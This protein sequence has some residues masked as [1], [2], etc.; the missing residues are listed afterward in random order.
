M[1]TLVLLALL[2][3][4]LATA[5]LPLRAQEG[6]PITLPPVRIGDQFPFTFE[7]PLPPGATV[8]VDTVARSWGAVSVVD[9]ES[10][11]YRED[12]GGRAATIQLLLAAFAPGEVEFAPAV[13]VVTGTDAAPLTLGA[14]QLSVVPTLASDAPLELSPLPPPRAIPGAQPWWAVPAIVLAAGA[15]LVAALAL[16]TNL[17][18]W[19]QRR[20]RPRA[21]EP[22]APLPL[23]DLSGAAAAIEHDPVAAYRALAATVRAALASRYG[24]PARALTTA[25]L[26]RRMESEGVDRWQARLVGGLLAECDAVVYAGYRPATERRQADL[27]MAREILETA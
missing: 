21:A 4:G 19:W 9:I 11:S 14:T 2:G 16:A 22:A 6:Q 3:L 10:V 15:G 23:P 8:E 18:R 26:E 7:V 5:A 13:L 24:F 20:P 27:N 25:E 12:P 1:R 17:A